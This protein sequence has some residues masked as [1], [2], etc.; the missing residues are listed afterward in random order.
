MGNTPPAALTAPR[1]TALYIG[2]LL[3]PSLMLLPGL[4][5]DLAGPASILAWIALLVLSGL[6]AWIFTCLGTRIT[7]SGGVVAYAQAGLGSAVGRIIGWCFLGG[8]IAGA[9][10]VS[11]IG[12]TYAA[13]L[14]GGGR[15]TSVVAAAALLLLVLMLTLGGARTTSGAQLALVAVLIL[16]VALAV[17]GSAHEARAAHWTPFLPHGWTSVGS[18][19]AVLMLSFVGWE[20]IAPLTSRFR[21]PAR[22][23]P[24]VIGTAFAVTTVV[25]LAL[26]TTTIAVLGSGAATL[27]PLAELLRVAIGPVGPAIAAVA[28]VALTLAA[29]NAYLASATALASDLG[30]RAPTTGRTTVQ[31]GIA[32]AGVAVLGAYA[33]DLISVDQ[34]VALPT[35]LF[36]TVYFGCTIAAARVLSGP[37]R[38]AAV[39]AT[40]AIGIVLGFSGQALLVAL[41]VSAVA[42]AVHHR[43]RFTGDEPE[44]D[45]VDAN[46][47][48]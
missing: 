47:S 18:A 8:V 41:G 10:A 9:P 25:Y 29:T 24:R 1:G 12:G 22:Q 2:A 31:I 23:L 19:G 15:T 27:V 42:L 21:D 7:N 33:V 45:S 11:L 43:A 39:V 30:T 20:A 26:A 46:R 17:A 5:A 6:L 38:A 48:A 40:V 34:L 4:A 36:L 35:T 28:A 14:V 32:V 3:G 44:V 16:L 37:V 13:T